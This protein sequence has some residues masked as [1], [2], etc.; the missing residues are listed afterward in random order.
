MT[1]DDEVV[2]WLHIITL[3]LREYLHVLFAAFLSHAAWFTVTTKTKNLEDDIF[4]NTSV[5]RKE[6]VAVLLF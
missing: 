1:S 2:C 5:D 6:Y 4:N 3:L